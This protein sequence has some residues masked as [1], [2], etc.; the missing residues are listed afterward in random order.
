MSGSR[1]GSSP[2]RKPAILVLFAIGIFICFAAQGLTSSSWTHLIFSVTFMVFIVAGF[3]KSRSRDTWAKVVFTMVGG[4]GIT[5]AILRFLVDS[6]AIIISG[7]EETEV[8]LATAR[9]LILGLMLGLILALA[10]SG[11]LLGESRTAHVEFETARLP[12]NEVHF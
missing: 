12:S 7:G 10:L 1:E 6:H 4:L 3:D 11:Q 2:I 9:G 8:L 5:H